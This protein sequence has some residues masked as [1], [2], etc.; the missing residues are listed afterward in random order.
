MI[1]Y[2]R[3]G[4]P[5]MPT[6]DTAVVAARIQNATLDKIK[7]RLRG[8]TLNQ[9]LIWAINNGLRKHTKNENPNRR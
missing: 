5:Y 4:K 9:W 1:L 3:G 7:S 2:W 6:R 8:R